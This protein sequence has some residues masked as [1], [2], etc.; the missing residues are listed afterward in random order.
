M[1]SPTSAIE[2]E[3]KRRSQQFDTL[4]AHV[5]IAGGVKAPAVAFFTFKYTDHVG[6]KYD[7]PSPAGSLTTPKEL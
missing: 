1:E 3:R 4:I 2:E 6:P 7:F 5:L